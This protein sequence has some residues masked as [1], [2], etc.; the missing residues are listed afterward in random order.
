MSDEQKKKKPFYKKWWVI[1]IA[2]IAVIAVVNGGGEGGSG[3]TKAVAQKYGI[4]DVAPTKYFNVKVSNVSLSKSQLCEYGCKP[5]SEGS[6]FVILDVEWENIG[7]DSTSIGSGQILAQLNG[8]E[9]AINTSVSKCG[10]GWMCMERTNPA[11]IFKG[12]VAF[13]VSERLD[14]TTMQYAPD[15]NMMSRQK[16]IRIDLGLE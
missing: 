1:V 11:S 16:K 7:A 14:F 9:L 15:K 3:S 8:Q 4:G 10:D 5:P 6:V 13:E 12:K 2:V